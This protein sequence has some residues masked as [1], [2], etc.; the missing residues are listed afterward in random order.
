MSDHAPT[1]VN[2]V[3]RAL[4]CYHG[5]SGCTCRGAD[6]SLHN[7]SMTFPSGTSRTEPRREIPTK[8]PPD[9]TTC[10]QVGGV[11]LARRVDARADLAPGQ[12]YACHGWPDVAP[13][14]RRQPPTM[15]GRPPAAPS[16]S[17]PWKAALHNEIHVDTRRKRRANTREHEGKRAR[18]CESGGGMERR[19]QYPRNPSRAV[20]APFYSMASFDQ[21]THIQARGLSWA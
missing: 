19:V 8:S 12:H 15:L 17:L 1:T 4:A 16:L 21:A 18:V 6:L 9:A 10:Y 2:E 14:R 5:G 7:K 13:S 11:R 20:R 3:R